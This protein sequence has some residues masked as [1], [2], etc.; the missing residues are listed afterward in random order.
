MSRFLKSMIVLLAIVAMATPV[1][2]EDMLSLGGQMRVRGWYVGDFDGSV[3]GSDSTNTWLDQRLRIGGKFSIA[4][5]VSVTFRTDVTEKNWG[6]GGN[7][8]GAGRLPQD[9]MQ[10][11]R[12]HM[13]L[14]FDTFSLRAGQQYIQF[15]QNTP[16]NA[17]DA[18]FKIATKGA[19]PVTAFFMLADDNGTYAD[20]FY[21]GA[22]VGFGADAVKGNFYVV[23][24]S[25][26]S[27]SDENVYLIGAD[28]TFNMDAFKLVAELD[29]FTGDANATTDA[30]G[31]Q[32]FLD[33]S[34]SADAMTFGAQLFYALGDTDD[35]QYDVLGN[36][37][38]GWDPL[39]A[40]G[41]GLDDEQIMLGRPYTF[42][43]SGAGVVAGRI[44][45][46]TKVSDAVNLGASI[47]YLEPEEDAVTDAD[48]AMTVAVGMKYAVMSNTSL[49]VLVEYIDIDEPEVDA[50]FAAGVGLFVNF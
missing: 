16:F 44:Y 39:F 5:G 19:V 14:T 42:F 45:V 38:N 25:K 48:S 20:G 15:G 40:H 28:T 2:A 9:G 3:G 41:T 26:V 23:G 31:T 8:Y 4:D 27:N 32:L 21:Y 6:D 17:Q 1:M 46:D 49:G 13:D 43:G 34:M 18:G 33:G 29:F 35:A 22:N 36:D 37:F 11:D 10:W 50:D 12:A 47:S 24:Q 30:F 7:T